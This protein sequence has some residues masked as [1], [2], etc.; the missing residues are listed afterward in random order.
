MGAERGQATIDYVALVAVVALLVAA[1]AAAV[2][3][4]A[5]GIANA[6][7]GQ[8][9]HALCI[10]S[11]RSCEVQRA[12]PCTVTS[13][14]DS[15]HFALNVVLARVDNDRYVLRERLSD[16]TVRLTVATRAGAGVEVG[17]GL[18]LQVHKNGRTLGSVDEA[19]AGIQGLFGH[20]QVFS[21]SDDREADAIMRAIRGQGGRVPPPRAV[22]YHGGVRE[23]RRLGLSSL[24][25]GAWFDG[26]SELILGV[27]KDSDG[28]RTIS[29]NYGSSAY[30]LAQ[31]LMAGPALTHDEQV[32]MGLTLDRQGRQ[33]EL[34]LSSA[35]TLTSGTLAPGEQQMHGRRREFTARVDLSDPD[36]AAAWAD[37]R[38][39]PK[40]LS[41]I[42]AL[43]ERLRTRARLDVRTYATRSATNGA[44]GSIGA[45]FRLGAE[46]EETVEL[47]R[48]ESAT[49]R[50]PGGLWEPRLDCMP[51][52]T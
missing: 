37:F 1:G 21:A 6:V 35:A 25:A 5:A 52:Q 20:G 7:L 17:V 50:P 9:H 42:S 48:L 51:M 31:A 34:S 29:L 28:A 13:T 12:R 18:H 39:N 10:V 11:G 44:A 16:G 19:S 30:A 27:Q 49:T 41:A 36:I 8:V 43:A 40:N 24:V 46:S 22:F 32:V 23:L 47:A 2:G 33:V 45:F 15:H 4:G 38:R 14:R 26:A 3:I